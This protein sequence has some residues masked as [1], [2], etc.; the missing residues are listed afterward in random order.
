MG[1]AHM[2]G[3]GGHLDPLLPFYLPCGSCHSTSQVP[4]KPP[5]HDTRSAYLNFCPGLQRLLGCHAAASGR[6]RRTQSPTQH[7]LGMMSRL[8]MISGA[9]QHRLRPL[10]VNI[11]R[12]SQLHLLDPAI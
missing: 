3:D 4:G 12:A 6:I 2:A 10:D 1:P 5:M 7:R 9:Y 8:S 11:R